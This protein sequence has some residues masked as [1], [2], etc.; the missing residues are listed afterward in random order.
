[1]VRTRGVNV[2]GFGKQIC[3]AVESGILPEPFNAAMIRAA[4][5]GWPDKDY[6]IILTDHTI[7]SGCS[8]E[9]F[10]RVSFGLYRLC[11]TPAAEEIC[12]QTEGTDII[13][14]ETDQSAKAVTRLNVGSASA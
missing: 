11:R 14:D 1:M 12:S 7:G 10:E 4:C 8:T 6:H 3:E 5:P 2:K 9:L 13:D